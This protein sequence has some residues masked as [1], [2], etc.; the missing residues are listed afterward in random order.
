[1]ESDS[2]K[3]N[4]DNIIK[5]DDYVILKNKQTC[6][7]LKV[8]K[9]R[10]VSVFRNRI[11]LNS[12]IGQQ[13][14]QR[15]E[16]RNNTIT[17][18][19]SAPVKSSLD[20]DAVNLNSSKDNRNIFDDGTSQKL[21]R[22][23]IEVLKADGLTGDKIVENLIENSSTFKEKT[24]FSQE[25]YRNKK[26]QKYE[27]LYTI[28]KPT[29]RLVAEMFYRNNPAK[30]LSKSL[31]IRDCI[32][33]L[34]ANA[35][36]SR[37]L[38]VDSLSQMLAMCN[39]VAGG[40]YL[41]FDSCFGLLTAAVM[42]RLGGKGFVVQLHSSDLPR[43]ETVEILN[44]AENELKNLSCLPI[45]NFLEEF[46]TEY[47]EE[48]CE[49]ELSEPLEKRHKSENIETTDENVSLEKPSENSKE[50][51]KNARRLKRHADWE[52]SKTFLKNKDFDGLL[53]ASKHDPNDCLLDLINYIAISRPI[54]IFC[55]YKEPLIQCYKSLKNSGNF[56]NL[57][58][59]ETWLRNYQMVTENQTDINVK[60]KRK[61]KNEFELMRVEVHQLK[62]KL[63]VHQ[64]N[65]QGKFSN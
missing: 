17:R 15:Y 49:K 25:K 41:V 62:L 7:A 9:S 57:K 5:E 13:F 30:I 60:A 37:Y 64:F 59:T 3:I 47:N 2:S 21:S 58:L 63:E 38:R 31:A 27:N 28:Y 42:H 6:L 32:L 53:I 40:K 61:G 39:V 34:F 54:T 44:F 22:S 52:V 19:A 26:K 18:I 11:K 56:I 46:C 24:E 23:D 1:M 8:T 10:Q 4:H 50:T 45:Q 29:L 48:E 51:E 20:N 35:H 36:F 55:P 12:I 16:I 33:A 43:R 14:G 65:S